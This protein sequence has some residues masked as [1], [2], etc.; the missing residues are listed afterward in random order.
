MPRF[1][2]PDPDFEMKVR[3]SFARQ[4]FMRT[5]GAI[6]AEVSPGRCEVALPWREDLCQ[7]HGYIHGGVTTALADTAAGYAAYTLMPAA[8][9]VLA[10]EFKIN[11]MAPA[12]GERLVARAEVLKPGRTLSVVRTEVYAEN[13]GTET[14]IAAM[15]STLI[16]LR[17]TPD[18]P[19][20]SG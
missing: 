13:E 1:T 19:A 20:R 10:T 15:L 18:A 6:L 3:D 5:V 7:Q 4:T 17:G 8:S 12:R 2:P 9:S 14:C 16:C 11:L